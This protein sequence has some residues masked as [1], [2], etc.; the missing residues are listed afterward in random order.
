M[1][2]INRILQDIS[3]NTL[4][5]V[6]DTNTTLSEFK[7]QQR[8][9]VIL[10][11]NINPRNC[12]IENG[13]YREISPEELKDMLDSFTK[14][15]LKAFNTV[16]NGV[17]SRDKYYES[18]NTI[19]E[20]AGCSR[21]TVAYAIA[22]AC[23]LGLLL[24]KR[25]FKYTNI[26]TIPPILQQQS[27][28]E[29]FASYLP[30]LRSLLCLMMLIP[31]L[32][33]TINARACSQREKIVMK[34]N[35]D[36]YNE[37]NIVGVLPNTN[38]NF[39][40]QQNDLVENCTQYIKK[41]VLTSSLFTNLESHT[42]GEISDP[43]KAYDKY[44][45]IGQQGGNSL[46]RTMSE[47]EIAGEQ[48]KVLLGE[49]KSKARKPHCELISKKDYG[50]LGEYG[51]YI[52]HQIGF[53]PRQAVK[54]AYYPDYVLYEIMKRYAISCESAGNGGIKNRS[55]FLY[56]IVKAVGQKYNIE[57]D[58]HFTSSL[59]SQYGVDSSIGVLTYQQAVSLQQQTAHI[60][61]EFLN[62][63][64]REREALKEKDPVVLQERA[65]KEADERLARLRHNPYSPYYVGPSQKNPEKGKEGDIS[66]QIKPSAPRE[67]DL[68]AVVQKQ[69]TPADPQ[70]VVDI[71][72]KSKWLE[73]K[74]EP[75]K[76]IASFALEDY[77]E[78]IENQLPK[79]VS[80]MKMCGVTPEKIDYHVDQL[81]HNRR[82]RLSAADRDA[83]EA[84]EKGTT[85]KKPVEQV[86][87][88]EPRYTIEDFKRYMLINAV[89][90][91]EMLVR[92]GFNE[93]D[94]NY[95]VS[96]SLKHE[97]TY[98]SPEDREKVKEMGLL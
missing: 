8:N 82:I 63:Q 78:F 46:G 50:F 15:G 61:R 23:K 88:E 30:G 35:K 68:S 76:K 81:K 38:N 56:G 16:L 57:L 89:S 69:K 42:G 94:A 40:S 52:A 90:M 13:I 43:E 24:R 59:A 27:I 26:Y 4:N 70:T 64:K 84:E 86:K 6:K 41:N 20:K 3:E 48:R 33:Y 29:R 73:E 87:E 14:T 47:K 54:L 83:L 31:G 2:H 80:T 65:K 9:P 19:A 67:T 53:T 34:E 95:Q 5:K 71:L 97:A 51:R 37:S 62:Y 10:K 17:N 44:A 91:K 93:A 92:M 79:I 45:R 74:E 28:V 25:Q 77:R 72:K 18:Y 55:K 7:H 66:T 75:A 98:L 12:V 11:N 22:K 21:R 49:S 85:Y 60:G 96:L 1:Y 32:M 36:C 58:N 39:L